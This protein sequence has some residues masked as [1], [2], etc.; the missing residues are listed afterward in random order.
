MESRMMSC[1][2]ADIEVVIQA[3]AFDWDHGDVP[4]ATIIYLGPTNFYFLMRRV[5]T[6]KC[7]CSRGEQTSPAD[8]KRLKSVH[9]K[10]IS[11]VFRH[12]ERSACT[13]CTTNAASTKEKSRHN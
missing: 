6:S 11:T 8:A 12:T 13:A 1:S 3:I 4:S 2:A 7:N 9:Y 10:I 5:V